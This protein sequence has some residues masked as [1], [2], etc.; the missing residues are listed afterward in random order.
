MVVTIILR[1]VV[2]HLGTA[3]VVHIRVEMVLT[4]TAM[5]TGVIKNVE[6]KIG[7]LIEISLVET[8]TCSLRELCLDI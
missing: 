6:I 7:M 8:T 5:E 2:T 3:M 1:N 4:I